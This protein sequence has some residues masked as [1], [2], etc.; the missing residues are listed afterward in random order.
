M[1]YRIY[2]DGSTLGN[3]RENAR[4]GCGAVCVNEQDEVVLTMT[5]GETGTTNQRMEL[6][7][8]LQAIEKLN[9]V[10]PLEHNVYT[11]YTD[12][13]YLHNC[14][15][16]GWYSNWIMNGWKTTNKHPVKNQDLWR[17]L[18]E[19]WGT[20]RVAFKKVKGHSG[21]TDHE[22]WNEMADRL[23]VRAA[24]EGIV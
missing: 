7:A 19:W 10:A 2:C 21:I 17:P 23:A 9:E 22:K 14:F 24:S 16:K 12:S 5:H 4:G 3:G 6:T 13:A 8:A 1:N 11:I 15:D 18:I 20:G